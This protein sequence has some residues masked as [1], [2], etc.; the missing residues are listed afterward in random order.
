M[1]GQGLLGVRSRRARVGQLRVFPHP[2]RADFWLVKR[3]AAVRPD[4][5]MEVRSDNDEAETADS[6]TFGPVPVKGSYRVVAVATRARDDP[7]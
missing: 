1:E 2:E 3:V 5:R 7:S 6:R 4:G